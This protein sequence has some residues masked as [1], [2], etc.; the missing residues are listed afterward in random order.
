MLQVPV[1]VSGQDAAL[2]RAASLVRGA[3]AFR[4]PLAN[5]GARRPASPVRP[6]AACH[7]HVGSDSPS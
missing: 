1:I 4:A 5:A 6:T 7:R 2:G 3:P